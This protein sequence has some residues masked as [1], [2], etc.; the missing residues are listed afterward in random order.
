MNQ[1]DHM[2]AHG[3]SEDD[4]GRDWDAEAVGTHEY[5][6]EMARTALEDFAA[7]AS[8]TELEHMITAA[9]L[10][11]IVNA[12]HESRLIRVAKAEGNA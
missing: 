2:R 10:S 5:K 7:F 4:T 3:L 6:A 11:L 12:R 1:L 9:G 8:F